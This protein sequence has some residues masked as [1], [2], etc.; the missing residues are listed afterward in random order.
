MIFSS[1]SSSSYACSHT[2]P[3]TI[4]DPPTLWFTD[5]FICSHCI[6]IIENIFTS[7]IPGKTFERVFY[8]AADVSH[9]EV[10][11]I[12]Q[13]RFVTDAVGCATQA[14]ATGCKVFLTVSSGMPYLAS[15]P[16]VMVD[17]TGE[18]EQYNFRSTYMVRMEQSLQKVHGLPLVIV[19]PAVIWGPD[20]R[21]FW[22]A[23]LIACDLFSR[24]GETYNAPTGASV[25][26]STVHVR[27]VARALIHLST[28]YIHRRK[29]YGEEITSSP[30]IYNLA[31]NGNTTPMDFFRVA[32]RVFPGLKA[33]FIDDCKATTITPAKLEEEC[34]QVNEMLLEGWLDLLK[35]K[36]VQSPLTPFL[37]MEYCSLR[38]Y[39]VDGRAIVRD[40]GFEYQ[41]DDGFTP[42]GMREVVKQ[43]IDEG[44]WPSRELNGE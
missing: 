31:D 25:S 35:S 24:A 19:R 8:C 28:W 33:N 5:H 40:T 3:L 7:P 21:R 16:G 14:V 32:S 38:P 11:T 6:A 30:V 4:P 27:D 42:Q 37:E 15:K 41:Y 26:Y 23:V 20:E 44:L 43:D 12:F 2:L 13:Q 9:W 10:E 29:E 18:M 39:T 36:G 17:E 22:I 1:S 34:D